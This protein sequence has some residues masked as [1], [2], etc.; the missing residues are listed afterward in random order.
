MTISSGETVALVG[1]SGAGKTTFMHLIPRFYDVE[2]GMI[3]IDGEDIRGLDRSSLRQQMALV[4][5]EVILFSGTVESN[6]RYGRWDATFDEI[7]E[8]AKQA[9]AHDFIQDMPEK[10]N[11][12]IGE[13]GVQLSGGQRQRIAIARSILADPKILL[14]DE[15]T[16]SLDTESE[17]QVQRALEN[18]MK[19]RTS[20]VIAHRLSTVMNADRILVMDHGRIVQQG[21]HQQLL[22]EG[23]LYK[24]LYELQFRDAAENVETQPS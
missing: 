2:H 20:V 15:A 4:P 14:L 7:Q 3:T 6:I 1:P 8:A 22:A 24:R 5:Q 19:G 16:S 11:T 17:I 12:P 21:T 23:G 18:L 13:R 9:N 10:Y